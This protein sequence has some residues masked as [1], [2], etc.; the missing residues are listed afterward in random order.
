MLLKKFSIKN[1]LNYFPLKPDFFLINLNNHFIKNFIYSSIHLVS[2][3][4]ET[5]IKDH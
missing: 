5:S 3:I 1:F 2:E 4:L